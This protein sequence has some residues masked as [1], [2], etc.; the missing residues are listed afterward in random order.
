MAFRAWCAFGATLLEA[1]LTSMEAKMPPPN[2]WPWNL[3]EAKTTG[4]QQGFCLAAS[5]FC[6]VPTD[7]WKSTASLRNMTIGFTALTLWFSALQSSRLF[8]FRARSFLWLGEVGLGDEED[9]FGPGGARCKYIDI[10]YMV[11]ASCVYRYYW[12][13]EQGRWGKGCNLTC[14]TGWRSNLGGRKLRVGS[15]FGS[16]SCDGNAEEGLC[17]HHHTLRLDV[18]R[19]IFATRLQEN[20]SRP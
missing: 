14:G 9:A 11:Q 15:T 18:H 20:L 7:F 13:F 10:W 16:Q 1:C 12:C 3:V 5:L 6:L 8:S 19:E 4:G 2:C 17:P